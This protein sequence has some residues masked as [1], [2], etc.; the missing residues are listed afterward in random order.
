MANNKEYTRMSICLNDDLI[1]GL[2]KLGDAKQLTRS[3]VT[4]LILTD[5]IKEFNDRWGIV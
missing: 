2:Q 3:A 4:R 1:N 5:G